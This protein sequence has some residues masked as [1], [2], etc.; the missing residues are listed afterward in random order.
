MGISVK[1]GNMIT[2]GHHLTYTVANSFFGRLEVPD[3]VVAGIKH[4]Q[5]GNIV[6]KGLLVCHVQSAGDN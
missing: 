6:F 4:F 2:V 3:D 5:S 1:E